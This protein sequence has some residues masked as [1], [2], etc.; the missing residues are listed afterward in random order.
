MN[1]RVIVIIGFIIGGLFAYFLEIVTKPWLLI[2]ST[3]CALYLDIFCLNTIT[4]ILINGYLHTT[5]NRAEREGL[6]YLL[7]VS[8]PGI[9][10]II[11]NKIKSPDIK[12][13]DREE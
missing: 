9:L 6:Q 7:A 8:I 4:T 13:R 12:K 1:H 10:I 2:I 3:I 5:L 11:I